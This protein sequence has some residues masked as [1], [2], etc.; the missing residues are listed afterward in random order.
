MET[1]AA[2]VPGFARLPDLDTDR[3]NPRLCSSAL[4]RDHG[5]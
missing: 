3:R 1:L 5:V 4:S 2:G